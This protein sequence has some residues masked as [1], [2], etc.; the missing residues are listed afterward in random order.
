[1]MSHGTDAKGRRELEKDYRKLD[2]KTRKAKEV[3]LAQYSGFKMRKD[4][5]LDYGTE[6]KCAL[7]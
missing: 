5:T 6:S 4:G 1:M 7:M 3:H 2:P